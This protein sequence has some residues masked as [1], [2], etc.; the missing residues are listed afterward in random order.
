VTS[1]KS[2]TCGSIASARAEH[3]QVRKEVELL[4][5]HADPLPDARRVHAAARDFLALE[6]DRAGVETLEQV[7]AAEERRLAAPA[8]A[9][10]RQDLSCADGQVD[11]AEDVGR[12]ETL[13]DRR[14][15]KRRRR[16]SGRPRQRC[17]RLSM[18]GEVHRRSLARV[19]SSCAKETPAAGVYSRGSAEPRRRVVRVVFSP[20]FRPGLPM[21]SS[22]R[23]PVVA[24]PFAGLEEAVHRRGASYEK[25]QRDE[26]VTEIVE[27][28]RRGNARAIDSGRREV[29]DTSLRF[30]ERFAGTALADW[31]RGDG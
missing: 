11:A 30:V 10:D 18:S 24:S 1:S 26:G 23:C 9:D 20:L 2:I 13:V 22:R 3:A 16:R 15:P 4:E 31:P 21:S 12:A 28:P 14:E 19:D 7:R 8:R 29:A 5:D 25:Q 27:L 17:A 6:P